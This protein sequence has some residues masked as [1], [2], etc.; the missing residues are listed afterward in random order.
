MNGF[1]AAT[2]EVLESNKRARQF[3]ARMGGEDV[4]RFWCTFMGKKVAERH[5]RFGT[6]N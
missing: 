2:R 1:E 6:S 3:Y 5:F 4:G